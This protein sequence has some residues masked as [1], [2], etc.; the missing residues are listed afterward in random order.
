[1]VSAV[2]TWLSVGL[3]VLFVV[4]IIPVRRWIRNDVL[5]RTAKASR[6]LLDSLPERM[7]WIE[8]AES[9]REI[10][11]EESTKRQTQVQRAADRV[12]AIDGV[13]RFL[14]LLLKLHLVRVGLQIAGTV[15]LGIIDHAAPVENILRSALGLVSVDALVIV[16]PYLILVG[17]LRFLAERETTPAH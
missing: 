16:V 11:M 2:P 4:G 14:Y 10:S 7:M 8:A 13:G 3:S 1:M 12:A 15:M 17:R 9:R 5:D 6:K